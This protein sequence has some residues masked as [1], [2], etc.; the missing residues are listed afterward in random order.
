VW[1]AAVV[2]VGLGWCFAAVTAV[3][4]IVWSLVFVVLPVGYLV[5]SRVV[6]PRR[7]RRLLSRAEVERLIDADFA[8]AGVRRASQADM[9]SIAG[10]HLLSDRSAFTEL[11]GE[12]APDWFLANGGGDP[13]GRYR[14]EPRGCEV[15]RVLDRGEDG[16]AAR[17]VVRAEILVTIERPPLNPRRT[18]VA[19]WTYIERDGLW[20]RWAVED[21]WTGHRHL[22][23]DPLATPEVDIA[24]L[25]D[26]AVLDEARGETAPA[27]LA[28]VAGDVIGASEARA[29]A[30]DL[31]NLDAR[32][33]PDVI[34]SCVR[35]ILAGWEFATHGQRS[36]LA[37]LADPNAVDQLLDS[38]HRQ[39]TV[40]REPHLKSLELAE[41]DTRQPEHSRVTVFAVI[42]AE[43]DLRHHEVYWRLR[44]SDGEQPWILENATAWDERYRYHTD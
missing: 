29:A 35:R 23:H 38:P 24:R 25:R 5:W 12:A 16:A 18:M 20:E 36:A 30:L 14:I 26:R 1:P 8:D 6:R 21:E 10:E 32:Y 13:A 17:V 2:K 40:I 37:G 41:L 11:F 28:A 15:I 42:R 22:G 27:E 34:E 43:P 4:A 19:Y 39:P 44:L 7:V 33:S 31:A 9:E 3:G